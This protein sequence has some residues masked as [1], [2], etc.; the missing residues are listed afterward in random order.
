MHG[1]PK[2]QASAR[3]VVLLAWLVRLLGFSRGSGV[4]G[5]GFGVIVALVLVTVVFLSPVL[6][7]SLFATVAGALGAKPL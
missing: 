3:F 6:E 4:R 7:F 2:F 5:L 1:I